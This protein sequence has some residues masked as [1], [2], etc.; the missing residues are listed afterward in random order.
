MLW[1]W[2]V[3]EWLRQESLNPRLMDSQLAASAS[4]LT[5]PSA[6]QNNSNSH[7]N[8]KKNVV[9]RSRRRTTGLL[10][11]LYSH[12]VLF[13]GGLIP[14]ASVSL[15]VLLSR[16]RWESFQ[17]PSS[18]GAASVCRPCRGWRCVC[19]VEIDPG[20]TGLGEAECFTAP[21]SLRRT[22]AK[23]WPLC[24]FGGRVPAGASGWQKFV[25]KAGS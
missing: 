12:A 15:P 8:N 16:L 22:V 3:V 23:V 5:P 9:W 20:G 13:C 25:N 18:V 24:G 6:L 21:A 14:R 19:A 2:P 7:N 1:A 10:H 4:P 11:Q 17:Q